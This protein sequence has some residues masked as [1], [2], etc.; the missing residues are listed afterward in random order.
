MRK[1]AVGIGFALIAAI[2][3]QS[4]A[5]LTYS[6]AIRSLVRDHCVECHRDGGSGPFP[7]QTYEQVKRR[8]S[9]IRQVVLN[10][11][12]PPIDAD[13]DVAKL[14][15]IVQISRANLRELQAWFR[16][17]MPKGDTT[18]PIQFA[19]LVVPGMVSVQVGA[20]RKIPAE[21]Q[22]VRIYYPV[23]LPDG[24]SSGISGFRVKPKSRQS[25]RQAILA[26]QA[27]GQPA[28]FTE[29]GLR[30][31]VAAAA[32]SDGYNEWKCANAPLP[33]P[34]GARLWMELTVIPSGKS[35]SAE[36]TLE[37]IPATGSAP[38]VRTLGRS[39]FVVEP[40]SQAVL[41]DEWT[42][43]RDL[44][45]VSALPQAKF[46]TAQLRLYA[47]SDGVERTLLRVNTW[48]PAW[49]GAYNFPMPILLKKGET[50]GYE[51][52]IDN[53]K[54]GHGADNDK[55]ERLVFG[56]NA[57]NELFWCHLY[58]SPTQP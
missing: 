42:L 32:M 23:D 45:L 2:V 12:M 43:D 40:E 22:I 3:G 28:P 9:L 53:S 50:I 38:I 7:L 14:S 30:P 51:A 47:K 34:K 19:D 15:R 31:N 37:L 6:T 49:P 10:G 48:D 13:S 36:A 58:F 21:G 57:Q 41:R 52:I 20:D 25:V 4:F 18:E 5:P 8:G 16:A 33:V 24:F 39:T 17:G 56:P 44:H 55:T 35:E 29:S 11:Q 54:H 27:P 26:V 46:R 1:I